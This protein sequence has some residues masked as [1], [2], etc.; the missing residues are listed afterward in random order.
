M[1]CLEAAARF[2]NK[3]DVGMQ[4]PGL[5]WRSPELIT[6]NWGNKAEIDAL[7]VFRPEA[8]ERAVC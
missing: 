1:F 6:C 3:A 8:R 2:H 4:F 5:A 7:R